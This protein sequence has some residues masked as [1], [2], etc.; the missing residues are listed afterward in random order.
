MRDNEGDQPLAVMIIN[1][2]FIGQVAML[3]GPLFFGPTASVQSGADISFGDFTP[4]GASSWKIDL[5]VTDTLPEQ[6][7]SILLYVSNARGVDDNS[8]RGLIIDI[9]TDL[10][11]GAIG[12]AGESAES[13][14][15][16]VGTI[17]GGK[18]AEKLLGKTHDCTGDIFKM[19]KTIS[20][21]ELRF[22]T[23]SP[24][25]VQL[26]SN[27][28]IQTRIR[29]LPSEAGEPITE[30]KVGCGHLPRA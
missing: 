14:L 30:T 11:A 3:I 28:G 16:M 4:E 2:E 23:D 6:N 21:R 24:D 22:Q 9:V 1:V 25:S 15:A 27:T 13:V 17:V 26:D 7:T 29:T 10:A 5:P 20:I 19:N 12:I 18:I 8:F